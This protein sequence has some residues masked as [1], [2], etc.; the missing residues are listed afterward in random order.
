VN[1]GVDQEVDGAKR[2]W[3]MFNEKSEK[4]AALAGAS[5]KEK[6]QTTVA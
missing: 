2:G 5:I 4:H 1:D 3:G 6:K